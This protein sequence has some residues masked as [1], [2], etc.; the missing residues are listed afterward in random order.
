MTTSPNT[1]Y[2]NSA[3]YL[4]EVIQA[5]SKAHNLE[6][7]T[8]VVRIA[9]RE[10]TNADGAT[11]VLREGENCFYAEE[12]AISPLWKGKR[13]PMEICISGWVMKNAKSVIIGDIYKDAR[14]PVEAYRPTF[15]KSLLMVPIRT[16][17][18]IGAIGNYWATPYNP[19]LEQIEILQALA[20]STSIAMENV[21]LYSELE[22]R[23]KDRTQELEQANS[24]L[25]AFSY[26]V[27]HDLRTPLRHI[28]GFIELLQNNESSNISE[29]SKRYINIISESSKKMGTLIDELLSFSQMGKADICSTEIELN[30]MVEEVIRNQT[31][32]LEKTNITWVIGALPTIKADFAMLEV[33]LNNLI[34]NAIKYTSTKS[35][36]RVEIGF[37][38]SKPENE[39]NKGNKGNEQE[40]IFIHDNGVG[41]DMQYAEKLFGVF[42]RLHNDNE[43]KGIG[44][45]LATVK[46]I[47]ERHNGRVWAESELGKGT[48]FYFSLPKLNTK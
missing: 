37:L 17:S 22:Q 6:D 12:N 19:T 29:K 36:P 27:S 14:I 39:G 8:R 31:E 5:L 20:D 32:M 33:V 47:I 15:V 40:I 28:S 2:F 48:T 16:Q 34:S 42:Q 13:F 11:F 35:E 46:R 41:F 38:T 1:N 45:G 43:F 23:V 4:I 9:A 24:E 25:E 7:I 21:K 44:I 3:K 30:P 26:S 18:P 10:L